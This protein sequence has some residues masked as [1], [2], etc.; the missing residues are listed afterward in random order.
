M[1]WDRS[2]I[3]RPF[4]GTGAWW[5]RLGEGPT[6]AL[7][8]GKSPCPMCLPWGC[9]HLG[10]SH[11]WLGRPA[12]MAGGGWWLPLQPAQKSPRLIL[13][14]SSVPFSSLLEQL[15]LLYFPKGLAASNTTGYTPT[16]CLLGTHVS[17][18]QWWSGGFPAIPS[19]DLNSYPQCPVPLGWFCHTLS[20]C[21]LQ[22]CGLLAF[23]GGSTGYLPPSA[24]AP[25]IT[26]MRQ[27][28][29]GCL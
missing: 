4:P 10:R 12:G 23:K 15:I 19:T 13:L 22:T 16:V 6:Q 27:S 1:G 9:W 5:V 18:K 17:V 28:S 24:A 8:G 14:L 11:S 2:H 20:R 26:A 7:V 29:S 21:L 25:T 3:P